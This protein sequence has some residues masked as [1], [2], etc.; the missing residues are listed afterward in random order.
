MRQRN[1]QYWKKDGADEMLA[2]V[3]TLKSSEIVKGYKTSTKTQNP[4]ISTKTIGV[5]GRAS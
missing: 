2:L 1:C 4:N 5:Q 3:K